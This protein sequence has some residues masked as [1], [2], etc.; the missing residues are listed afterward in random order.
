[1][2]VYEYSSLESVGPGDYHFC[3]MVSDSM[4]CQIVHEMFVHYAPLFIMTLSEYVPISLI[5]KHW[6]QWLSLLWDGIRQHA[7]PNSSQAPV[8]KGHCKVVGHV[9]KV[10]DVC[11]SIWYAIQRC[12]WT[13]SKYWTYIQPTRA[14]RYLHRCCIFVRRSDSLGNRGLLWVTD[15]RH[16]ANSDCVQKQYLNNPLVP[17]YHLPRFTSPPFLRT[18][19]IGWTPNW[20]IPMPS[21]QR[22]HS[23]MCLP[24]TSMDCNWPQRNPPIQWC[25]QYGATP[26]KQVYLAFCFVSIGKWSI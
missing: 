11:K 21:P 2:T 23:E 15:G 7:L 9:D 1:M 14:W 6:A 12:I 22:I 5:R 4:P 26:E 24:N 16:C 13:S 3:Q 25:Q 8:A 19:K 18:G 10:S 17:I 20:W